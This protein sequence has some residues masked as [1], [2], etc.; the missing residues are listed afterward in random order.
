MMFRLSRQMFAAV[1]MWVALGHCTQTVAGDP[2]P[3]RLQA[4]KAVVVLKAGE[5]RDVHLCWDDGD[6]RSPVVFLSGD[7][8]LGNL[9]DWEGKPLVRLDTL[10]VEYDEEQSYKIN[11][12]MFE[13]GKFAGRQKD[14]TFK[15]VRNAA[16]KVTAAVNTKPGAHSV[17]IH[18]VSGTGRHML[19]AGEFRVLVI[20]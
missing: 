13:C 1:L 2:A 14:G 5:S 12:A 3:K 4:P 8:I 9:N 20:E 10:T 7:G 6:G 16:I 11:G 18:I 17:Y 19:L 15:H